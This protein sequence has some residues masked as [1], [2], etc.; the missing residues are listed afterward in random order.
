MAFIRPKASSTARSYDQAHLRARA[1]FLAQL[2]RTGVDT[3]CICGRTITPGM[4]LHLD[5]TADRQSY[6]GLAHASCNVRDGARRGRAR[7]TVTARR[8]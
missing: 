3:C 2:E 4:K 8:M 7:Q 5:H 6:R 1:N